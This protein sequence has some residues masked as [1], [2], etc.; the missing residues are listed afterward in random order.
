[1]KDC[2]KLAHLIVKQKLN[3]NFNGDIPD[4]IYQWVR[5]MGTDFLKGFNW[6]NRI[7][8]TTLNEIEKEYNLRG[9]QD[10]IEQGTGGESGTA[11]VGKRSRGRIAIPL[12]EE[13]MGRECGLAGQ[14]NG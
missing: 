3:P 14:G 12:V 4:S 13:H 5:G 2:L 10:V 9:Q 1:M 8:K 11:H 6:V 7:V